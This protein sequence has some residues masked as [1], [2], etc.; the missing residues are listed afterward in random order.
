M[1]ILKEI[2]TPLVT[3]NLFQTKINSTEVTNN[4]NTFSNKIR[5]QTLNGR[6]N[7]I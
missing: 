6:N 4:D 3:K 7:Y 1:A 5:M 2:R